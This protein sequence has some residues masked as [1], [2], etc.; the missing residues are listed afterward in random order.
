[1]SSGSLLYFRHIPEAIFLSHP[2]RTCTLITDFP[3][4]CRF[5]TLK[6]MP[7]KSIPENGAVDIENKVCRM[8]KCGLTDALGRKRYA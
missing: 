7:E 1:M 6:C 2:I 4:K 3:L 8:L 5:F